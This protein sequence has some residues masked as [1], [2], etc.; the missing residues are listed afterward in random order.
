MENPKIE[1]MKTERQKCLKFTFFDKLTEDGA[2]A[3]I[4]KW[5]NYFAEYPDDKIT[6]IWDCL[7]MSGYDPAARSQWQ[8][9]IKEMKNQ[10]DTIWLITNSV[11]IRMGASAMS[12]FASFKIKVVTSEKEINLT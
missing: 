8:T 9:T 5:K 7:N 12:V 10:M 2:V 6:L 1:W 3:G 11:L 4:K